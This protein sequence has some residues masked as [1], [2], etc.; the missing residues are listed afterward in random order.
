MAT[1]QTLVR[2]LPDIFCEYPEPV[3]AHMLQEEPL[4]P[5]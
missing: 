2:T 3:E 5:L 1:T 4:T